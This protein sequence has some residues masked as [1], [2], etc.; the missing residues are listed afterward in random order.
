MLCLA[1]FLVCLLGTG[2]AIDDTYIHLTYARNLAAG[3]GLVFRVGQGPLY[4]CTSPVWVALLGV[5]YAVSAGGLWAARLLSCL[6]GALTLLLVH[7]LSARK[8]GWNSALFPPLLLAL[9]PWWVRWSSSGMETPAA[10]LLVAGVLL[11]SARERRGAAALLSGLGIAVRPEL[12]VLGPLLVLAGPG[13][14][15]MRRLGLWALPTAAWVA[16]AWA[17]FGSPLP[18]SAM[19]KVAAEPLGA[20]LLSSMTR[21][22]GMLLAGDALQTASLALL[23]GGALLGGWSLPRPPRH[24]LPLILLPPV[25]A[26]VVLAGRG[27]LVSRYVLP[28]WPALVL[29][30]TAWMRSLTRRIGGRLA[31]GW[32]LLPLLAAGM[33]LV[34]LVAFFV[35]HMSMMER[36]L[37]SYVDA[38]EYLRDSLPPEAVVAVHEVGVFQY[39]SGR[40]LVDL[41]GLVSPEVTPESY[42]GLNVNLA[43]S[44]RLL[45][46]SGATHL[47]DPMDRVR[48]IDSLASYR[49]GLYPVPIR[50]WDFPGGTSIRGGDY[51]RVLYRLEWTDPAPDRREPPRRQSGGEAGGAQRLEGM[52]TG[53]M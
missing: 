37:D 45:R 2:Y 32:R 22:A 8:L 53:A 11:L 25:M 38:A 13:R 52:P 20:Y 17:Y 5:S 35:P 18:A 16:W 31:A 33:Q 21:M 23:A 36:H 44:V 15:R 50:R 9:N 43:G 4:S 51:S 6:C 1:W 14:R 19:S 10:G 24:W 39:V 47:M 46:E 27:P 42:P 26:A 12:A 48:L 29:A 28:A 3:E 40:E 49:V 30:E 7:R 41:E 34:I